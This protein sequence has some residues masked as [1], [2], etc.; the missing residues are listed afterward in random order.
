MVMLKTTRFGEIT[1]ADDR[2]IVF[3]QGLL[4]FAGITRYALL[5]P[6]EGA[7]PFAWLQAVEPGSLAFLVCDPAPFVPD[8]RV[9]VRPEDLASLRMG[10]VSE[11]LVRVIVTVPKP[12]APVTVNLLGPLVLNLRER[13]GRQLVL[14][15]SG[16]GTR[17]PLMPAA[18][19]SAP[20]GDGGR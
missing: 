18:P 9:G 14:S 7:G 17:H 20:A 3:E 11:G 2:V 16:Y 1:V 19:T 12:P 4:G 5:D 13:L 8:Y 15:D 6:P 10:D